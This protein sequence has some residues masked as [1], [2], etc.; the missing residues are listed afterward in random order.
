M[1]ET[2][3]SMHRP[4]S[5]SNTTTLGITSASGTGALLGRGCPCN[6]NDNSHSLRFS[7]HYRAHLT[8]AKVWAKVDQRT[9]DQER[10]RES[11]LKVGALP[12]GSSTKRSSAVLANPSKDAG[13]WHMESTVAARTARI[14]N[15]RI[16]RPAATRPD[17]LQSRPT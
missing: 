12:S 13:W 15:S 9:S 6:S 2:G 11:E 17:D 1:C 4:G 3:I 5:S 8:P 14:S 16:D 10:A 7:S